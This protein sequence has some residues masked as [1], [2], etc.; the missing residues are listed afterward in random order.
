MNQRLMGNEPGLVGYWRFDEGTGVQTA[1]RSGRSNIGQLIGS[2]AW[3]PSDAPICATL[4]D[5]G[6]SDSGTPDADSSADAAQDAATDTPVADVGPPPSSVVPTADSEVRDGVQSDSNFG[7]DTLLNVQLGASGNNRQSYLKFDLSG[8]GLVKRATLRLTHDR[9]ADSPLI[10]IYAVSTNVWSE[11]TITWNNRPALGG[12]LTRASISGAVRAVES[13][14][15]TSF[16]QGELAAGRPVISFG[17][18]PLSSTSAAIPFASREVPLD[19]P[20]LVLTR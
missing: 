20:L 11:N 3:V 18:V 13:F 7:Q 19:A 2:P 8:G 14:D 10:G 17:I 12:E 15:V 16:V 9:F 4:A 6:T 1:D 5:G